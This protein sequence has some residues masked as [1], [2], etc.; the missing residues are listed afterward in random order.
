MKLYHWRGETRNFGDEL[1]LLLWPRLLPGLFDDDESALFLGI[2]SVLD[3]RHPP[4]A[5]KLVAGAGYGGYQPPATLDGTW[6]IHWVRGPRTARLLGLPA[7]R[8]AGDPAML[9]PTAGWRADD[10]RDA[11]AFMPHFE[12]LRHGAWHEA[13]ARAGMALI[14]PRGDSTAT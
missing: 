10:D 3:A 4:E 6:R 12:S 14:D 9:L 7:S 2:G 5:V 8:G 11:I 13:T 1:N